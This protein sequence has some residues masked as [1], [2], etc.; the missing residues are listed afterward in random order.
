MTNYCTIP[1]DGRFH[2]F[3]RAMDRHVGLNRGWVLGKKHEK[4]LIHAEGCG[5]MKYG[6]ILCTAKG[7]EYTLWDMPWCDAWKYACTWWVQQ[8]SQYALQE[9]VRRCL[10]YVWAQRAKRRTWRLGTSIGT[11]GIVP[12]SS[13][14]CMAGTTTWMMMAHNNEKGLSKEE[15]WHAITR[16]ETK[17]S[18]HSHC[19]KRK[20]GSQSHDQKE[21]SHASAMALSQSQ[22]DGRMSPNKAWSTT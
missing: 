11:D 4:L 9:L 5:S 21:D 13:V 16:P 1:Q 22:A 7:A 18:L 2:C 8:R 6:K 10:Q 14:G 12:G 19:S 17:S 20:H 3:A 15:A